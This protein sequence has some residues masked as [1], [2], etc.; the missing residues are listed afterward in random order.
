MPVSKKTFNPNEE[1]L[2]KMLIENPSYI[3]LV[4]DILEPEDLKGDDII[5]IYIK[6]F[7]YEMGNIDSESEK[8]LRKLAKSVK[9]SSIQKQIECIDILLKDE[10]DIEKT[11]ENAKKRIELL[12]KMSEIKESLKL[13]V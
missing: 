11:L 7:E 3:K 6:R 1:K 5:Q 10:R 4:D 13:D 8:L 2:K 12:R 9:L